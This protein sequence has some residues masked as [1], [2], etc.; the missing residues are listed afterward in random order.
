MKKYVITWEEEVVAICR[1]RADAEEY[2]FSAIEETAYEQ[3]LYDVDTNIYFSRMRRDFENENKW[4]MTY[5]HPRPFENLYAYILNCN[6]YGWYI[7][8]VEELELIVGLK[9]ELT[10]KKLMV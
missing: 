2:I 5:N 6:M 8:E 1:T 10:A 4:R 7:Q 3:S 9:Q